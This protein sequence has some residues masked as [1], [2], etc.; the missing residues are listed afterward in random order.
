MSR[1][2]G[3]DLRRIVTTVCVC[4]VL[5]ADL[6]DLV[7]RAGPCRE[8]EQKEESNYDTE[9]IHVE[10]NYGLHD[11][12]AISSIDKSNDDTNIRAAEKVLTLFNFDCC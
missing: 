11:I 10:V 12:L 3:A 5:T 8:E 6:T 9:R 2:F 1:T 4:E 7:R